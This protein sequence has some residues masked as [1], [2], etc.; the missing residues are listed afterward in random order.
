LSLFG[1]LFGFEI[2]R[3]EETN[4]D[5]Q[6]F[7]QP[8]VVDDIGNAQLVGVNGFNGSFYNSS[9]STAI[10]ISENSHIQ[11][12]REI[13]M[14]HEV[15]SAIEEIVTEAIIT[16]ESM[17]SIKLDLTNTEFSEPI[18]AKVRKS[19]KKIYNILDFKTKGYSIFR[20]WYI[21]GRLYYHVVIDEKNTKSGIKELRYIDPKKIRRIRQFVPTAINKGATVTNGINTNANTLSGN[22]EEYFLYN[23]NGINDK[24]Q[25]ESGNI[26]ISKDSIAYCNSGMADANNKYVV[27]F[28]NKSIQTANKLRTLENSIVIYRLVRAPERRIFY[29]D[30]GNLPKAR[31]EQY[32]QGIM[33]K[34]KTKLTYDTFTGKIRDDRNVMAMTEDFY[35]PRRDGKTSTEIT[36]LQGQGQNGGVDELDYFKKELLKSLNVPYGRL[37]SNGTFSM[38]NNGEISKEEANFAKFIQRLR[39]QFNILFDELLARELVL[40]QVMSIEEWE[41]EKRNVHY[42]YLKDN[43]FTELLQSDMLASRLGTLAQ[44]EPFI[45]KYFSDEYVKRNILMQTDEEIELETKRIAKEKDENPEVHT[46]TDQTHQVNLHQKLSDID[47]DKEIAV[48]AETEPN[49]FAK[50]EDVKVDNSIEKLNEA[51]TELFKSMA[52]SNSLITTVDDLAG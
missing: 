1:K 16:D 31:A 17:D 13:A 30:V 2:V 49:P 15:D 37:D 11:Q 18:K 6:T 35:I 28:L 48:N 8:S 45:G 39:T 41:H 4:T 44:A 9:Q 36:T 47:M 5:V 14:Y 26:R 19:F 38:G 32:L 7:V 25:A 20:R 12:C 34:Y 24:S 52:T 10:D 27:S 33:Q 40:T 46:P 51:M 3:K 23:G 29:I 50:N 22:I 42:D 21:D 43:Y